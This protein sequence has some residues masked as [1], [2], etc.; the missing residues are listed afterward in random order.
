MSFSGTPG[1][2]SSVDDYYLNSNGLYVTETT[3]GFFNTS[4]YADI[5]GTGETRLPPTPIHRHA[6]RGT[7][8]AARCPIMRA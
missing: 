4:L 7:R 1:Y 6:H 2:L 5:P 3:N 8:D